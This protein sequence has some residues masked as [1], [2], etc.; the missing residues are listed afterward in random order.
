MRLL[1]I[2]RTTSQFSWNRV[3]GRSEMTWKSEVPGFH[4]KTDNA[5]AWREIGNAQLVFADTNRSRAV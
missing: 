1:R 5:A 4:S 3:P 2:L